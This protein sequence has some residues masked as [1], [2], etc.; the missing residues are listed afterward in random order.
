MVMECVCVCVCVCVPL[1]GRQ[2]SQLLVRFGPSHLPGA[3]G[4]HLGG[5]IRRPLP[6]NV[7]V[8]A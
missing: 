3:D 7:A 6:R 4:V 2:L 1:L 5:V 8:V